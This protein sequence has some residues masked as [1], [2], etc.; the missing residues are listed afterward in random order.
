MTLLIRMLD[1]AP[2][3]I[4]IHDT[5]GRFLFSNRQNILLHGYDSEEQFLSVNLHDLDMPESEALLNERFRQIAERGEA[6][7]KVAHHR[8]DG[9]TF[10][11]DV[12]AKTIEWQGQQAMLSIA[13]DITERTIAEQALRDSEERFRAANDASLD[14]LMLLHSERDE[15]GGSPRFRL[16]GREPAHR[17][18][19]AHEP[20]PVAGQT[21]V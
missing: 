9:S 20:R 18:D 13:M 15:T 7:F 2:A 14:A 21:A 10:P 17:G 8:K 6:R 16:H 5:N 11:L 4:T 1:D 3:A 12:I 19:V